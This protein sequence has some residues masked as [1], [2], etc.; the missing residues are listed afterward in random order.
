[1]V[2]HEKI[3]TAVRMLLEGIGE[4]PEREGLKDT[5]ARIAR[6]YEEIFGGMEEDAGVYLSR[7]FTAENNEIVLEKDITLFSTCEHHLMPCLLYTSSS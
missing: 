1:M 6:M 4:D 3:E 7:T 2:N 5:P